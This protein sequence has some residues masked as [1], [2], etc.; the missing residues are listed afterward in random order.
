MASTT[1]DIKE[2]LD[3]LLVILDST[4]VTI[5]ID[6]NNGKNLPILKK[7]LV[8]AVIPILSISQVMGNPS[9]EPSLNHDE[10]IEDQCHVLLQ[11][12]INH[13]RYILCWPKMKNV[14]L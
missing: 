5:H 12:I 14:A 10:C 4:Q 11:T 2:I 9:D 13:I 7:Y 8:S 1:H 3:E 6:I